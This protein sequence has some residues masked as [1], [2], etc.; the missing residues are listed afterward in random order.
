MAFSTDS[1][2]IVI[3]SLSFERDKLEDPGTSIISL[4]DVASG[5]V[6]WRHTK[7]GR[8]EPVAFYSGAVLAMGDRGQSM[9][10]YQVEAG[11][12]LSQ[13]T[14]PA[15]PVSG[16]RWNDFTFAKRGGMWVIGGEDAEQK[17]TVEVIDPDGS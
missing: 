4:A 3:G 17:G 14:R 9:W 12:I 1:K 10:F 6:H 15:D 13:L 8:P 16:G 11:T 5:V 7:S 2:L